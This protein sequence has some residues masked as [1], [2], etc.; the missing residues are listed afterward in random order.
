MWVE[1]TPDT[2][3][4]ILGVIYFWFMTGKS[5]WVPSC[6]QGFIPL[7]LQMAKPSTAIA[8]TAYTLFKGM[9]RP[10]A[11]SSAAL[12]FAV[13]GIRSYDGTV[14]NNV[15]VVFS[16]LI[17]FRRDIWIKVCN[18]CIS[19]SDAFSIMFKLYVAYGYVCQINDLGWS[20]V[21]EILRDFQTTGFIRS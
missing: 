6:T 15:W 4:I 5:S 13:V 7:L 9:N 2:A 1:P 11:W 3:F 21:I 10:R 17:C 8:R 12:P 20:W 19:H 16:K 14:L 18:N